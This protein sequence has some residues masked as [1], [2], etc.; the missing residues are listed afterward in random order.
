MQLEG[1]RG[2]SLSNIEQI[3]SACHRISAIGAQIDF[4]NAN[5]LVQYRVDEQNLAMLIRTKDS[6]TRNLNRAE[7][8]Q[9]EEERVRTMLMKQQQE[10]LKVDQEF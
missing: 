7:E 6:F 8:V 2:N 5:N 4:T 10:F 3:L 9:K 1:I